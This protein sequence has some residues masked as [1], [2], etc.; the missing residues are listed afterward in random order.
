MKL[1]ICFIFLFLSFCSW[2]QLKR[3]RI[4][5]FKTKT[6]SLSD[7]KKES[8]LQ[9]NDTSY[10]IRS[11]RIFFMHDPKFHE[12]IKDPIIIDISG[13]S[14]KCCGLDSSLALYNNHFII[15]IEGISVIDKKKKLYI[16]TESCPPCSVVLYI[17][18]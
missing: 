4:G 16:G 9:L 2:G 8:I 5:N 13:N 17:T 14:L 12:K 7:F 1:L 10:I 11:Y 3:L 18:D 15:V 6:L